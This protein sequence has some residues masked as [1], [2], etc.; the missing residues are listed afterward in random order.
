[1][2]HIFV[3]K[4]LRQ[5][6]DDPNLPPLANPAPSSSSSSD[7]ESESPLSNFVRHRWPTFFINTSHCFG[8]SACDPATM[9]HPSGYCRGGGDGVRDATG[10]AA[11]WPDIAPARRIRASVGARPLPWL[12]CPGYTGP[13]Q[14]G[15]GLTSHWDPKDE[16]QTSGGGHSLQLP[17]DKLTCW[18]RY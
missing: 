12:I 3:Q 18:N 8:S 15:Q 9:V 6:A 2:C 11:R 13:H 10:F 14:D 17:G 4:T 1:M 16:G 5:R 7:D